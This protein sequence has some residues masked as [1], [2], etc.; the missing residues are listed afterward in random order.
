MFSDVKRLHDALSDAAKVDCAPGAFTGWYNSITSFEYLS[1]ADLEPLIPLGNG[2]ASAIAGAQD[3]LKAVGRLLAG[4]WFG[5]GTYESDA[6]KKMA[7]N[8]AF[9]LGEALELLDRA[10]TECQKVAM[11]AIWQQ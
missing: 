8:C 10:A 9:V 3:R 5:D 11:P 2:C 4:F 1:L 7:N 6:R